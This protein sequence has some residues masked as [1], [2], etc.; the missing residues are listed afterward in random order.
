MNDSNAAQQSED[1][2]KR[3]RRIRDIR[4]MGIS[5]F[6]KNEIPDFTDEEL[7]AF[8][9]HQRTNNRLFIVFIVVLSFMLLMA[10]S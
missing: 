10:T 7:R 3:M 2:A 5:A 4:F 8:F 1:E 6:D 9:V